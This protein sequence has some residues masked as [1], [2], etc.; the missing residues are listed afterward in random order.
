MRAARRCLEKAPEGAIDPHS[1]TDVILVGGSCRIPLLQQRVEEYFG[2]TGRMDLD[3]LEVVALGAAYQSEHATEAG[4]LVTLHSLAT[5]LGVQ[6][7]GTDGQGVERRDLFQVILPATAKLP[8]RASHRFR[9]AHDDQE[10]IT[11]SIYETESETVDGLEPWDSRT[12]TGLPP[13]PAGSTPIEITFEYGLEQLLRVIVEIEEMDIREEWIAKFR[14]DLDDQRVTS[15]EKVEEART[16]SLES[17]AAFRDRARDVLADAPAD[18]V[19]EALMARLDEAIEKGDA[20]AGL[21]VRR[22][23]SVAIFDLGLSL[24]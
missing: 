20:A 22:E 14:R 16:G 9:T 19:V 23:L 12:I 2:Q 21:E 3:H 1:V 24:A 18:A 15:S 7:M 4:D 13:A 5:S 17:L 8:A 10:R 6:C 11:I